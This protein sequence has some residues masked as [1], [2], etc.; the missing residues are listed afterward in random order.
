MKAENEISIL[1]FNNFKIKN[2]NKSKK[3]LRK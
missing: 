3:Y 2:R 1:N